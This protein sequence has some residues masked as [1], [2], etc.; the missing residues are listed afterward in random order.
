MLSVPVFDCT[1]HFLRGV[2]DVPKKFNA[3]DI[4]TQR[5]H[6]DPSYN[7]E[8]PQGALVAIHCTASVYSNAKAN[9]AKFLSFNLGAGQVL[10]LPNGAE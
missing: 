4:L 10:A 1:K 6:V 2:P 3:M 5:A 9:K 8:I 7:R